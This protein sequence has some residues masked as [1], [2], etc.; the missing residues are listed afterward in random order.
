M[1]KAI[2]LLSGGIDS[3]VAGYMMKKKG[4]EIIPLHFSIEPFTNHLPEEKAKKLAKMLGFKKFIVVYQHKQHAEIVEKCNHR[5]YYIL[6]RRL[7]LRTAENI[8]KKEMADFIVTGDNLGQVGSQTLENLVVISKSIKMH[9]LRPLLTNDKNETI[10]LARKIGTYETSIGKE[11]CT[12]LGPKN[13]ATRSKLIIIKREE[14]RLN[15]KKLVNDSLKD[16][17]I[18]NL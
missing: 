1:K 3:P 9:I 2:L 16:I 14:S 11:Y 18:E 12:V 17:K 5:Y 15:I 10:A 4:L 13:P 6:T 8:A 7:M